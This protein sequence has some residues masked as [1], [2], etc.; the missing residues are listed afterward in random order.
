MI[1]GGKQLDA[2]FFYAFFVFLFLCAF[3][4]CVFRFELL[5]LCLYKDDVKIGV[6]WND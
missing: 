5:L 2:K 1:D 3:F 6:S 4:C